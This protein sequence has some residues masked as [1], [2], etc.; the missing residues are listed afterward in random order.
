MKWPMK[1]YCVQMVNGPF[2]TC[3]QEFGD[4]MCKRWAG[5]NILQQNLVKK[6]S[7]CSV[8]VNKCLM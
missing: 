6:I 7:D 5:A 2:M 8:C 1:K 4:L 3:K